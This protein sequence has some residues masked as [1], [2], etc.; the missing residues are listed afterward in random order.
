VADDLLAGADLG[1]GAVGGTI[2]VDG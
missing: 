1:E 2:Q